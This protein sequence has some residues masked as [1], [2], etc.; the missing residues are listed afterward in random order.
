MTHQNK[1]ELLNT[2]LQ[3]LSEEGSDGLAERHPSPSQRSDVP[4]ALQGSSGSAL[5]TQR[6]PG[7]A[8][9][10]V[11]NPKRSPLASV[12]SSSASRKFAAIRTSIPSALDKGVRS[13]Q[14]LKLALARMPSKAS[15]PAKSLPL[16]NNSAATRSVQLKSAS[17]PPNWMSNWKAGATGPW[18]ET[19]PPTFFWMLAMKVPA[20]SCRVLDCAVLVAL[21]VGLTANAPFWASAWP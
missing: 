20:N 18:R 7:E 1:S 15:P 16:S 17:A 9:P 14:A 3:L 4:G 12:P 6:R 11:L 13:E 21:D 5:R 2:V 8:M 19:S 10:T